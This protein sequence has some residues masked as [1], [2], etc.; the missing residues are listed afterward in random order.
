MSDYLIGCSKRIVKSWALLIAFGI[1]FSLAT[2]RPVCSQCFLGRVDAFSEQIQSSDLVVLAEFVCAV[3]PIDPKSAGTST[4]V[5]RRVLKGPL[6]FVYADQI[7][8]LDYAAT[9]LTGES[10][11]LLGQTKGTGFEWWTMLP[12]SNCRQG[13]L[14]RIKEHESSPE[15]R[16]RYFLPYLESTDF[17]ADLDAENEFTVANYT[18]LIDLTPEFPRMKLRQ[19]IRNPHTSPRRLGVYGVMLG[20]CGQPVDAKLLHEMIFDHL[21]HE[22]FVLGLDGLLAGYLLVHGERGL[23]EIDSKILQDRSG[24]FSRTFAVMQA[25][26]FLKD[27]HIDRIPMPRLRDSMR[28]LLDRQDFADLVVVDLARMQDWEIQDRLTRQYGKNLFTE[29]ASKRAI[30]RFL[31]ACSQ[32]TL[33]VQSPPPEAVASAGRAVKNLEF[34]RRQDPEMVRNTERFFMEQKLL[35]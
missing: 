3:K 16:L 2:P 14:D 27:C 1:L 35:E 29:P 24:S 13:Y 33:D 9:F 32:Q 12:F 22:N 5:V 8:Q 15:K 25:I 7:V 17:L 6:D 31:M 20:M 34:L 11:F 18:D 26:R 19:W 28:L 4:L 21:N 10:V 30:I 23:A